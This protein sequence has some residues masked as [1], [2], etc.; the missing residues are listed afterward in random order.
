M[1]GKIGSHSS[2]DD[3]GGQVFEVYDLSPKGHF[4]GKYSLF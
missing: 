4:M 2:A 1:L 3:C